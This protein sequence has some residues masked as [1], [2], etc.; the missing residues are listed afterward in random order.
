MPSSRLTDL[1]GHFAGGVRL[2]HVESTIHGHVAG[3][4]LGRYSPLNPRGLDPFHPFLYLSGTFTRSSDEELVARYRSRHGYVTRVK[5]AA[6]RLERIFDRRARLR[7]IIAAIGGL[8]I[9]L[10][11]AHVFR[12]GSSRLR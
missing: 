11:L 3:A 1:D 12:A 9:G 10:A 8:G 6:D 2:P 4:P 7:R 5:R